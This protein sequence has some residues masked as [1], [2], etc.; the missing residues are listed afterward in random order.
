MS[1]NQKLWGLVETVL[2]T[3]SADR[4][5]GDLVH[6]G[7]R[8]GVCVDT[9]ANSEDGMINH[10]GVFQLTK[11][12]ADQVIAS[13]DFIEFVDTNKVQKHDQGVKI[14]KA[15][16]ASGAGVA[17]VNVELMPELY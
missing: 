16:E 6:E 9:I 3:A 8:Y 11:N 10:R 4:A 7:N 5:A 13:G 1:Q 12:S 14:G 17:T 2:I 15:Y